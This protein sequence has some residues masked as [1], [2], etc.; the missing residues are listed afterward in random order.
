MLLSLRARLSLWYGVLL[1]IG[2]VLAGVFVYWLFAVSL[3]NE[4]DRTLRAQADRIIRQSLAFSGPFNI[5]RVVLP[6]INV[7][8]APEIYV[9]VNDSNGNIVAKSQNLGM[10][11]LPLHSYEEINVK[12]Q[13][14]IATYSLGQ[15]QV[16][17]L[18]Y[19]L[20][21]R[22]EWIGTLE[23]GRSMQGINLA[24][25]RL[26]RIL[27]VGELILLMLGLVLAVWL[28]GA[29]LAP[30]DRMTRAAAE[31]GQS[32]DFRRRIPYDG[33][34]DELGR[35]SRTFNE[36]LT[37]LEQAYER[38]QQSFEM[39]KRF[40]ADASHELRTPLTSIRGN[41]EILR[42]AGDR[43]EQLREEALSDIISETERLTR[44]LHDLLQ[45]ARTDAGE[46]LEQ[47]P[48]PLH[49]LI[50]DTV[51]IARQLRSDVTIDVDVDAL[52]EQVKLLGNA[53]QIQQLLL[54]LFDN[55]TKHAP[56]QDTI[57]FFTK[58]NDRDWIFTV[59]DHGPGI[60][61]ADVDHIFERFY[62][63]GNNEPHI[64]GTGLGLAIARSIVALH[65]G[66]ISVQSKPGL[67]RF[68]VH[69]PDKLI[70]SDN[71]S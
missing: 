13:P 20:W 45:L 4:T 1:L 23:V 5:Q 21:L 18:T 2:L 6:D 29:A 51:R 70:L 61:P 62:R 48:F 27:I 24:L 67:T 41:A 66:T 35:L 56:P 53:D 71:G 47:S 17:I 8:S 50:W 38:V 14:W 22:G 57:R 34:N 43:D 65:D 33:P 58:R 55:A 28:T 59:E 44:L 31:I 10:Q 16:R 32:Q 36:M 7:F 12:K 40:V 39:Q 68:T 9:Q 64:P 37:R 63:G 30:I 60:D 19:P 15:T 54:I 11:V 49:D 69:L 46:K 42:R 25:D 3:L 26:R 52:P